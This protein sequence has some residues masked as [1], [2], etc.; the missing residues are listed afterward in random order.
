MT[1]LPSLLHRPGFH[2]SPAIQK[3][4]VQRGRAKTA[5][6]RPAASWKK[7]SADGALQLADE[8]GEEDAPGE[9][10]PLPV[11]MDGEDDVA[12]Y[13]ALEEPLLPG[14]GHDEGNSVLHA[15]CVQPDDEE[16]CSEPTDV[17]LQRFPTQQVQAQLPPPDTAPEEALPVE[18]DG[19][20]VV[21]EYL[22]LEEPLLPEAGHDE[23]NAVLHADCVQPDDE[24]A[25]SEPTDVGVQEFPMQQVQAQLSVLAR[26]LPEA[27]IFRPEK[28]I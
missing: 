13:L 8:E 19:D 26:E 28:L 20:D 4:A 24:E 3:A 23:G 11:E 22:A 17:G 14:A 12:E 5:A 10:V 2:G 27:S 9:A 7:E 21:V 16:A 1:R 6:V 25:C 18:V 15:D